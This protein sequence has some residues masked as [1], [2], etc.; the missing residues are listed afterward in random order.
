MRNYYDPQTA[1]TFLLAGI[2]V[3]TVL[4]LI[5]S[6]RVRPQTISGMRSEGRRLEERP[7]RAV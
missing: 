7:V 1:L 2:G 3:G 4:T 6:P 5:L